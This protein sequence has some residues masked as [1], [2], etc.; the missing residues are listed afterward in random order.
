[1]S[2]AEMTATLQNKITTVITAGITQNG[3]RALSDRNTNNFLEYASQDRIRA[4]TNSAENKHESIMSRGALDKLKADLQEYTE[5]SSI[6]G[7]T[8]DLINKLDLV[9]FAGYILTSNGMSEEDVSNV[10]GS[11]SA[12][13]KDPDFQYSIPVKVTNKIRMIFGTEIGS[14]GTGIRDL[15]VLKNIPHGKLVDYF[16][17]YLYARSTVVGLNKS[18]FMKEVK[19]LLNAGHLT[20]VFTARL[21]RTFGYSNKSGSPSVATNDT[22]VARL[23]EAA[24]NLTVTADYLSS[25][26][27]DDPKLFLRTDKRL[28]ENSVQLRLTTEVQ[29]RKAN[30][31]VG[32]MLTAA[33]GYLSKAIKAINVSAGT[34]GSRAGASRNIKSLFNSLDKISKFIKT[35]VGELK[36]LPNISPELEKALAK[37]I[38]S[39]EAIDALISSGGSAPL[40][41]H[42]SN[43]VV[44]GLKGKKVQPSTSSAATTS[45]IKSPKAKVTK[46]PKVNISTHSNNLSVT[47]MPKRSIAMQ[48]INLANLQLLMDRHLQDVVAANMGSGGERRV[49]NYQTGRLA[50]SAKVER[51]TGTR[52]GMITAFY[53]Y[54]RN[55]YGTFSEGGK[56]QYPRT[57]DPKTLIGNS[58]REIAATVVGNRMRA[59]L[60]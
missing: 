41:T 29:F 32:T 25:N 53:S 57:R 50:S 49:L 8:L 56:Q 31:D 44:A 13:R 45:S 30:Q 10:L 46:K 55:P 24:I 60:V 12:A 22:E 4:D 33:G 59:V 16:V 36:K 52:D 6:P 48:P 38:S 35:R 9:D 27:Y 2:I 42:I 54:M 43:I 7:L 11:V 20:G 3:T 51:L 1:M 26:I 37:S 17:E 5:K 40:V 14:G 15:I 34:S 21:I 39:V 18:T 23:V 58:I 47:I 28:F 19:G